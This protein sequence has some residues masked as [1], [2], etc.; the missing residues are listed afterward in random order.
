MQPCAH[1]WGGGASADANPG[2]SLWALAQHLRAG[3]HGTEQGNGNEVHASKGAERSLGGRTEAG[4]SGFMTVSGALGEKH[5]LLGSKSLLRDTQSN[6]GS[7]TSPF[8]NNSVWIKLFTE[9]K[10]LC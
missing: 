6:L 1:P 2:G 3:V 7:R 10:C 9:R 4:G 8:L 5:G